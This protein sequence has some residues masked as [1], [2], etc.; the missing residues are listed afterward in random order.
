M[1]HLPILILI[2]LFGYYFMTGESSDFGHKKIVNG[3][4]QEA[5]ATFEKAIATVKGDL[6]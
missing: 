2:G 4:M 3:P 5:I 1:R 6:H